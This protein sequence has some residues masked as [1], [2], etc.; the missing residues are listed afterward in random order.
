MTSGLALSQPSSTI[1]R[2]YLDHLGPSSIPVGFLLEDVNIMNHEAFC[3]VLEKQNTS[4]QTV[5]HVSAYKRT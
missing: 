4:G 5:R 2:G 1:L 3:I